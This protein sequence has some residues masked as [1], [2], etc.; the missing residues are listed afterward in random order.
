MRTLV[1]VVFDPKA[2]PLAGRFEALELSPGQELLPDGLPEA[3]DFSERHGVMRTGLE[4]SDARLFEFGLEAAGAAPGGVLAAVVGEHLFGRVVLAH[5]DAENLQDVLGGLAAE[6]IGADQVAGVIVHEANQIG[7]ATAQTEGEDVGLPHLVGSGPLEEA[8]T[9]QI[10]PRLGR[11]LNQVF[12]VEG[13]AD[14]LRTGFEEKD[15]FEQLGDALDPPRRVFL[16]E[17]DDLVAD[18]KR[19]LWPATSA[20]LTLQSLLTMQPIKLHPPV[21]RPDADT[22]LLGDQLAAEALLEVQG[23][24]AEALVKSSGNIFFA[25]SAPR[26][27]CVG[28][29][30]CYR[31][32]LVHVD[33]SL[34]LK[35]QPFSCSICSHELVALVAS[36]TSVR[37]Y[38]QAQDG[39]AASGRVSAARMPAKPPSST[40]RWSRAA[41]TRHTGC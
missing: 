12:F 38:D 1:V 34:T 17:L 13:L 21:H 14:R 16:L 31:F 23:D 27:G 15:S 3:L 2:D 10:A 7:I 30:L 29:L 6:D 33:T 37:L 26:G 28:V 22:H 20:G 39:W 5:G 41:E 11:T 8:G 36:T 35:C 24:G 25:R 9:D 4:V 32:I 40:P 19:H 18:C